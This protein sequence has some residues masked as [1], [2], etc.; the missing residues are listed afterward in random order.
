VPDGLSEKI[1]REVNGT[2][3]GIILRAAKPGNPVLLHLHGGLPE[4]FLT[5]RD[6]SPLEEVFTVA[7]WEQ[8]G[9]G[10]SYSPRI[11]PHTIT[12][13]QLVSDTL[14]VAR[15]LIRRFGQDRI[16]LLGHSG[17]SYVG[18]QAAARA[19]ELF[20]SYIGVGQMVDQ[21]RSERLAWEYMIQRFTEQGDR[22][23]VRRLQAAEV[24]LDGEVPRRY[25]AVRDRAMHALGVGTTRQMH[26]VVTGL[27]IPSLR[28][29]QYSWPE[30]VRL[31]RGK[32]RAGISPLWPEMTSSRISEM[33]PSLEIPA[34]FLH[35]RHDCT[36]SYDL[37]RNF[38][39]N[40]RAPVRG[41]YTF[42]DSAHSPILE[43]PAWAKRILIEDVLRGETRL[44]D[45]L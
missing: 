39:Q 15:Y 45:Q 31:W 18:I 10:L 40:L 4:S 20:R 41:F 38:A 25:L 1:F 9:A 5:E 35:G 44:A 19:P 22:R 14:V 3:Q 23:M 11:A 30:K 8:R 2:T 34:Y 43:E 29:R 37:A 6:P 27:V 28:A 42:E 17:G 7:W 36:C 21:L 26:S 32:M 24:T 13:E 33:V 12:G 16:H